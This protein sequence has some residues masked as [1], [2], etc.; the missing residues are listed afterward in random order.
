MTRVAVKSKKKPA[1]ALATPKAIAKRSDPVDTA[2]ASTFAPRAR[3]SHRTF[4]Q[5]IVQAVDGEK[6]EIKFGKV[7]VKWIVDSYVT[8]V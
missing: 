3:V 2:S 4:G 7:G 1:K 8:R 5:G 6:L